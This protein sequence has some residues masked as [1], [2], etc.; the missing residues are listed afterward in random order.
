[1]TTSSST[2]DAV[3]P[4]VDALRRKAAGIDPTDWAGHRNLAREAVAAGYSAVVDQDFTNDTSDP[5]PLTH[6]VHIGTAREFA[7]LERLTETEDA[8]GGSLVREVFDATSPDGHYGPRTP[9]EDA[10]HRTPAQEAA[11]GALHRLTAINRNNPDEMSDRRLLAVRDLMDRDPAT[12][13]EEAVR[14]AAA[15]LE[16][17]DQ[18]EGQYYAVSSFDAISDPAEEEFQAG[19]EA[20][21][22]LVTLEHEHLSAERDRVNQELAEQPAAPERDRYAM[23]VSARD[24]LFPNAAASA[25]ES[26]RPAP[27]RPHVQA[28]ARAAEAGRETLER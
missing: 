25:P 1:M 5:A 15:D 8:M 2:D 11:A 27:P 19:L 7:E 23:T 17:A 22:Q 18:A 14:T 20:E 13:L 12:A 28:Q 16:A 4:T 3:Q 9:W 26:S 24:R 10:P 21:L 6:T